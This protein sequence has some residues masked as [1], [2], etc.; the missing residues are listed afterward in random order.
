METLSALLAICAGNSPVPGEFPTQRPVTRS[1]DVFFY[2]RL[3]KLLS[4]QWWGWWFGTLS[5]PLW[6]HRN[7]AYRWY[8]DNICVIKDGPP[9]YRHV[10][11]SGTRVYEEIYFR[12]N[13]NSIQLL[14][15]FLGSMVVVF[16]LQTFTR[17]FFDDLYAYL[18]LYIDIN[19][20]GRY[21]P[22]VNGDITDT[23]AWA[24]SLYI[25]EYCL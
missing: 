12:P 6:R 14:E 15:S 18:A 21:G 25:N 22:V 10:S 20:S 4:I 2:L 8:H 17:N 16:P 3:D 9:H 5:H 23:A 11:G 13:Y 1:F 24:V 19:A 7:E